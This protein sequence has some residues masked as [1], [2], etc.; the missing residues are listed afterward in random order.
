MLATGPIH[1]ETIPIRGTDRQFRL[2]C[3]CQIGGDHEYEEWRARFSPTL[4]TQRMPRTSS[5]A[6]ATR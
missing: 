3:D 4:I 1:I 2:L 5:V 6:V